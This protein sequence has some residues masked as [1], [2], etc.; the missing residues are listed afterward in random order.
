ME[1]FKLFIKDPIVLF[2]FGGLAVVL[3]ICSYYV[4]YFLTQIKAADEKE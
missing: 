2:S 3:V 4:Y 1:L